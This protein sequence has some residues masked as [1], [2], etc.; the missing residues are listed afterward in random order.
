MN[1][2]SYVPAAILNAKHPLGRV[3]PAGLTVSGHWMY[4]RKCLTPDE[5][6]G[7]IIPDYLTDPYGCEKG[8]WHEVLAVGE[9]VG[10]PRNTKEEAKWGKEGVYGQANPA[11]S[12]DMILAPPDHPWAIWHSPLAPDEFFIDESVCLAL[13]EA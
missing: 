2:L 1:G 3:L 8:V 13:L 9:K 4:V 10:K 11:K 6:K 7:I 5:K 12:G